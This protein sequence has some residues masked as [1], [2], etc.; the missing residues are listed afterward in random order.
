AVVQQGR[1]M[2]GEAQG[3]PLAPVGGGPD[4]LPDDAQGALFVVAPRRQQQGRVV[5]RGVA[6]GRGQGVR[7]L[8]Q[9]GGLGELA[10]LQVHARAVR[11]G[12]GKGGEG[13]R[14]AGETDRAVGQFVPRLVV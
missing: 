3:P 14:P 7:L 6:G 8:D 13:A 1:R 4:G 12:D 2:V 9:G 11:Q 5:R 10:C